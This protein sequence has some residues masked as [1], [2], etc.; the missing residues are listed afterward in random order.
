MGVNEEEENKSNDS[1]N[2][3]EMDSRGVSENSL[4]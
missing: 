2:D 1:W 3:D 4:A